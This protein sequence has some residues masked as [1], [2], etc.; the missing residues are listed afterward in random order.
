MERNLGTV[1]S[2]LLALNIEE[3]KEIFPGGTVVKNMPANARDAGAA[4]SVPGLGRCPGEGNG[5][6]LQYACLEN[7]RG[8]S[9]TEESGR[10]Q[11]VGSQR[12]RHDGATE[13]T[14]THTHRE[15]RAKH[16]SKL[17]QDNSSNYCKFGLRNRSW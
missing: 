13:Q 15:T 6:P 5:I 4:G 2:H 17:T 9:H 7:T 11:S 1:G 3:H 14:H 12:V 10:L 8:E 16:G